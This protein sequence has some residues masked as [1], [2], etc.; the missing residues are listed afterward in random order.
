MKQPPWET[1]SKFDPSSVR[2]NKTLG[3]FIF[4]ALDDDATQSNARTSVKEHIV[5]VDLIIGSEFSLAE[6]FEQVRTGT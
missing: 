1:R 6:N 4:E 3:T 5:A 2:G